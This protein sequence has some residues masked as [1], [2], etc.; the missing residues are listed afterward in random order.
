MMINILFNSPYPKFFTCLLDVLVIN[1]F[2]TYLK[3]QWVI[4]TRYS[5]FCFLS[6]PLK[7]IS[8]W[9]MMNLPPFIYLFL[10]TA[11]S[12]WDRLFPLFPYFVRN[13]CCDFADNLPLWYFLFI[14][15]NRAPVSLS[16][17]YHRTLVH[18]IERLR[19]HRILKFCIF[20][21]KINLKCIFRRSIN[22]KMLTAVKY[23][24]FIEN[25][26][27]SWNH[28]QKGGGTKV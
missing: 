9:N 5:P 14:W 12:N 2:K 17:S 3:G 7:T 11:A 6:L 28:L 15:H 23:F 1:L 26:L 27:Q 21:T 22:N 4:Y 10:A 13:V 20:I 24:N 19:D 8:R 16:A 25:F 18:T